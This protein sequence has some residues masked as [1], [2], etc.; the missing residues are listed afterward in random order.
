MSFAVAKPQLAEQPRSGSGAYFS[1]E[2]LPPLSDSDRQLLGDAL[3]RCLLP[4]GVLHRKTGGFDGRSPLASASA[5][6]VCTAQKLQRSCS[7]ACCP[8]RSQRPHFECFTSTP[9]ACH[10]T[11][12]TSDDSSSKSSTSAHSSRSQSS[13]AASPTEPANSSPS[14][15]EAANASRTQAATSTPRAH[16]TH[17]TQRRKSPPARRV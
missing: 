9:S 6:S 7:R 17:D 11:A 1:L 4:R 2:Q 3:T 15:T 5:A 14:T 8:I 16:S 12:E 10:S 13:N